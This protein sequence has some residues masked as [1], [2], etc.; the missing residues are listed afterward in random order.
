MNK[1]E[2]IK[3]VRQVLNDD[4]S[5]NPAVTLAEYIKKNFDSQRSFAAAQ[6]VKQS[7]ITQWL[8]KDCVV[9]NGALYSFRRNLTCKLQNG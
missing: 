1:E 2:V 4:E 3:I 7:Q 6:G 9:V 8:N 5:F